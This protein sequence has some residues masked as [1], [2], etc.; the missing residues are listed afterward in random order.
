MKRFLVLLFSVSSFNVSAQLKVANIF[1]DHMVLQRDKPIHIWGWNDANE[2]VFVSFSGQ[3]YTARTNAQGEWSINIDAQKA[4]NKGSSLT[5]KD[6]DESFEFS[7]VLIGEVWLC[8]GQSNMEWKVANSDNAPAE[9]IKADKY[10]NI[11]HIEIPKATSFNK[12][13]DFEDSEWQVGSSETAGGF[14]AVGYFMAQ[15]LSDELNVPIGLV[16]SSWGGSHVETWI[17]KE[18]MLSSELFKKYAEELPIDAE[19]GSKVWIKNVIGK[20]HNGN[21]EFDMT[22]I[23]ENDYLKSDYDF[24]KW[25]DFKPL[26]QWDWKGVGGWR[27]TVYIEK[28][29]EITREDVAKFSEIN[30]GSLSGHISFYI[31]GE[32]VNSGFY[33]ENIK[34]SLQPNLWKTGKNS[35][36]VK[37]A[38]NGAPNEWRGVGLYG[39]PSD[40]NVKIGD[41]EKLLMMD[42]W[43]TRPSWSSP[44]Y[45]TDWM[46]NAGTITYNAMIAP[47]V[48]LSLK[49][50][51]WYQ[52]ES[53]AG[54]AKDYQTAFPL[55]IKDWR[56]QWGEDFPFFWV[57]LASYGPENDS[58]SGSDWAELRE[59]QSMT[60]ALPK[61]GQVVIYDN[62]KPHD[63]H[64]TNKQFVGERMALSVLNV[65]YGKTLEY[66]GPTYK[67]MKV[68]KSRIILNFD[69]TGSGLKSS[70][71][72]GNLEGFEIA[73]ADKKFYF[74]KSEIV[75]NTVM[76]S[77]PKVK[78]PVAVRYAWSNAPLDANLLNKEGLPATP[79]RTDTWKGITEETHFE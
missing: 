60:L 33:P 9:L 30:F 38:E 50:A 31:N 27:G 77:H 4:N 7:D 1:G 41:E 45:F 2:S 21:K 54:R 66:S 20:F 32:L 58:N 19:S 61:T 79:F 17:S 49:G 10:P 12:E 59:A 47:L 72:Y 67:S 16:H 37:F 28:D 57:Q 8:S 51:I 70:N 71:K 6:K 52:G 23:N 26:G 74:A 62:T 69:H 40:F 43:K 29:I 76:V 42:T 44:W 3:S 65:A 22:K 13:K 5:I 18:A 53:N 25:S 55:M 73:G 48:G 35:L 15:K 63:I 56:S 14:T 64:P 46:N 68:S 78:S 24:S 11:R 36:L 34:V 39:K 75:R